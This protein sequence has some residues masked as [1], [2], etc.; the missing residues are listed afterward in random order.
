MP[1][2]EKRKVQKTADF[3]VI[4][5]DVEKVAII[6]KERLEEHIHKK[7]VM[8]Q[9]AEINEIIPK[10]IEIKIDDESVAFLYEPIACHNYNTITIENG[11]SVN[12]AT[13]DTLLSFYLAFMYAKKKYYNKDKILC[14][15]MFLFDVQE[16]NR[17]KQ[18]GLLKRFSL[19]CIGK[20]STLEQIRSDKA[21]KYKEL[22]DK[23]DTP[24]YDEWFLKYNPNMKRRH[25][26]K[27]NNL[28]KRTEFLFSPQAK[29]DAKPKSD[30][31]A[32]AKAKAKPKYNT[33]KNKKGNR[34][35]NKKKTFK[36]FLF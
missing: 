29:H 24:E 34:R 8:I 9:H 35:Y 7:I 20:Q 33:N 4:V 13:I 30:E 14:M 10:H 28:K 17:L 32:K 1:E 5:E 27:M 3:D 36:T 2:K 16:K 19:K 22:K 31:K 26:R 23:K 12:V 11:L 25:V 15:A 21:D 6:L 18:R